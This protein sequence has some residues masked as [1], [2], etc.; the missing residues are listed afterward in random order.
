MKKAAIITGASR[1]IGRATAYALAECG[2]IPIINYLN[3]RKS[4]EETA[5]ETCGEVFRADI[6]DS[7]EVEGMVKEVIKK[8]GGIDVLVN[9]AGIS[10]SG[11]FTDIT[12]QQEQR[13]IDVNIKGVFNCTR[14]VIP[15][16]ISRKYGRIINI[17]SMWG[18]V[19]ASCEVH[20]SAA[21]AAVIGFTKALAKEVG[22]SGITVNCVSPGLISTDMNA[23][24]RPEDLNAL[25]EETPLQR[26]GTPEDV[27]AAIAFLTS[28]KSS[29][30]TGQ[31]IGVNGGFVI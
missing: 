28:D 7:A 29:F 2:Y 18:E 12:P 1:G 15:G 4:A 11:L 20:Y 27:A 21:K 9:N 31:V 26:M 30:I 14:H 3:S 22:P 25:I 16:M 19:G 8:Y 5:R 17:A 13:I 24:H 10:V 23:I 6:S